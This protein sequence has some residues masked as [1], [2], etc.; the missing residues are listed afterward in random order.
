MNTENP[1][2][3]IVMWK[4]ADTE[5]VAKWKSADVFGAFIRAAECDT[6]TVE[7]GE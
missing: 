5:S 1:I 7:Y 4:D 2:G 6:M 3:F